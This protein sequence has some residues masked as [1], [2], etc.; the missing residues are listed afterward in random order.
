MIQR[1]LRIS[2]EMAAFS[3]LDSIEKAAISIEIRS[4]A[5][6]EGLGKPVPLSPVVVPGR[7]GTPSASPVTENAP[8]IDCATMSYVL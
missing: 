4:S 7:I 2:I 6:W 1:L 3:V 5:Q 8:D